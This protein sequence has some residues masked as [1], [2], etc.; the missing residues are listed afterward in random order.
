MSSGGYGTR[1]ELSERGWPEIGALHLEGAGELAEVVQA[2]ES[3]E[4]STR[5]FLLHLKEPSGPG[6]GDWARLKD[7]VECR[8]DVQ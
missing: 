4:E 1:L 2:G 8:R 3:D 6:T 7:G 5:G